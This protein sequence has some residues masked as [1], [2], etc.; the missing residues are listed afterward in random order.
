MFPNIEYIF[1]AKSFSLGNST[2]LTNF[3]KLSAVSNTVGCAVLLK[4]VM[5]ALP[6]ITYCGDRRSRATLNRPHTAE[7]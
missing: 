6:K 2:L 7:N 5:L 4:D 3:Q 1:S